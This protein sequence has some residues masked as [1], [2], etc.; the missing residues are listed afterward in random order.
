MKQGFTYIAA[1]LDRSSSMESLTD[2]TIN[3]FNEFIDQ[4]KKVPGDG[5]M[6]LCTFADEPQIVFDAVPLKHV[7]HLNRNTYRTEGMTALN[8]AVADTIDRV[9]ARLA[10]MPESERPSQ[11]IVLIITDGQ[12]NHSVKYRG[13]EGRRLVAQKIRHQREVYKWEF[14]LIGANIDVAKEA[15]SFD[16]SV[17]N[18]GLYTA[19]AAGTS[20]MLRGMSANVA[21]YRSVG[22]AQV[23]DMGFF[24]QPLPDPDLDLKVP[25]APPATPNK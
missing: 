24:V 15:E 22:A 2:A 11:V 5:L 13:P 19:S 3:G 1:I 20:D 16:I 7:A 8:D 12:E 14:V 23:G 25:A 6:T 10:G 9:G 21:N 18:A 4:Q 17:K